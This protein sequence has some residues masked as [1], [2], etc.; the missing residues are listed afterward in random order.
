M[1][2]VDSGIQKLSRA[3]LVVSV[4]RKVGAKPIETR[5]DLLPLTKT[6]V[7]SR[8]WASP[9]ALQEIETRV[10]LVRNLLDD[11]ERARKEYKYSLRDLG[12]RS[13]HEKAAAAW[14]II[15]YQKF[16]AGEYASAVAMFEKAV[17]ICPTLPMIHRNW[18]KMEILA[19]SY[20]RALDQINIAADLA[21]ND[22]RVWREWA[23]IEMKAWSYDSAIEKLSRALTIEPEDFFLLQLQGEIEK[24]RRNYDDAERL[25]RHAL[26]R[27]SQTG[28]ATRHQA[29]VKTTLASTLRDWAEELRSIG[30][31][32]LALPKL[33]EAYALAKD[34][35]AQDGSE[36]AASTV[37]ES[38]F[39]LGEM[40][41]GQGDRKRGLAL[42]EEAVNRA[43][44]KENDRRI[45]SMA[46]CHICG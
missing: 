17:S 20:D 16:E 23:S 33:S 27:A 40:Y 46:C 3:F 21:P 12:A 26:E 18:A 34:A 43:P 28:V 31:M 36:A 8:P 38:A 25:L 5:Y 30:R 14:A 44:M 41:M 35:L 19:G 32:D 1:T 24:R 7:R 10:A 29:I 22:E 9:D 2:E 42:L 37:R 11:E 13:E 4:H 39:D 15:G 45:S 6:Y